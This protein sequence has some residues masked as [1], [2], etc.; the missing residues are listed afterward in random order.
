MLLSEA[1]RYSVFFFLLLSLRIT[2]IDLLLGP[3]TRSI[4]RDPS[5]SLHQN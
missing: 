4:Q 2:A 5:H 3:L 1:Q